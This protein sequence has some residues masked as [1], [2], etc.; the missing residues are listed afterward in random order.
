[1]RVNFATHH[2][3]ILEMLRNAPAHF[4]QRQAVVEAHAD[5]R[6]IGRQAQDVETVGVRRRAVLAAANGCEQGL[7][8]LG[9][10]VWVVTGRVAKDVG[11][12]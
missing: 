8:R 10:A 4:C 9:V 6:R 12:R 2:L 5:A 11:N 7:Y 1:M 3:H